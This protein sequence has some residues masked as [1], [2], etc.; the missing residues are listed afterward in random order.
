[1]ALAASQAALADA[2]MDARELDLICCNLNTR[3]LFSRTSVFLQHKLGLTTLLPWI[4]V[5]S[6]PALFTA[7]KTAHA[8]IA[9]GQYR[10]VLLCGVE[11]ILA[12][13]ITPRAVVTLA[14]YL[15]MAQVQLYL[16]LLI[17][18]ARVCKLLWS[19]R[20]GI[21][22]QTLDAVSQHGRGG[23]YVQDIIESGAIFPSMDGRFVFK[24]AVTRMP[25]VVR[26]VLSQQKLNTQDVD[27]FIFHQANLRI[28]QVVAEQI[29]VAQERSFNNIMNYGNC[30]A[31]SIP[32]C[33]HEAKTAGRLESGV[34]CVLV[35][36]ARDLPGVLR[37]FAGDG[38]HAYYCK[39]VRQPPI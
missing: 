23:I 22:R 18:T 28:N 32:M 33:I 20:K 1:M 31:A 16:V 10:N 3:T 29:G 6:A 26:E 12:L 13:L 37:L 38:G 27:L 17:L 9:T 2:H 36:L 15:V 34:C 5:A 21:C 35:D 19:M 30:S 14:C 39:S 24:H 11:F 4:F 25:E 8:L 7:Y